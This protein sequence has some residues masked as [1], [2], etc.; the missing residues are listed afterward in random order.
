MKIEYEVKILDINIDN[1]KDKLNLLWA[2][3]LWEDIQ[4]RYV[5]DFNPIDPNK[6]VRLRQKWTKSTLTVKEILDDSITWTKEIETTV[7]DFDDTNKI[8]EE[9]WYKAKAYQENKRISYKLD[10]VEVEL[11]FW[12]KIPPY[13]EIEWQNEQEVEN[14]VNKLWFKMENTTSINTTKVY[15]KY[16]IDLDSIEYLKF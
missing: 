2:E 11:D 4:K 3:C 6:W 16:W 13:M 5:Y 1:I 9:L 10:W 15:K 12:P 7:W 8:L 14:I